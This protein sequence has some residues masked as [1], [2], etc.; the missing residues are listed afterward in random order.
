MT[1]KFLYGIILKGD[2]MIANVL[3]EIRKLDKTFSYSIP[4]DLNVVVGSRVLVPFGN[5]VLEGFV[6]E[7][8][9]EVDF[10]VKDIIKLIDEEPIL[11]EELLKLGN[12]MKKTLFCNLITCYQAMLPPALKANKNNKTTRKTLTYV[13]KGSMYDSYIPSNQKEKLILEMVTKEIPKL[14]LNEI[15]SYMVD[16]LIKKEVLVQYSKEVYRLT[17]ED[18]IE[19]INFDLTKQQEDVINQIKFNYQPYLLH[20]VTGSGKTE[21]Y[22]R[23]IEEVLKE[24]KKAIILLPEISLTPQFLNRFQKRFGSKIAVLHSKLSSGEKYDEWRKINKGEADIVIGAR[25]AV[26]APFKNIGII[27]LDEEHSTTYKQENNPNYNA[28]DIALTR[29]KYH[30]CPVV[31]GSAT[32]SV[33]SY[34]RAKMGIYKL[35]EM[36]D[37]VNNMLPL[38]KCIDM[39]EEFKNKN[40]IFSKLLTEKINFALAKQEQIIVLL[41]R[42]G[43]TT[44]VN[45]PNCGFVHKCD[46]C[47]IPLTYHLKKNKMLCH[48]CNHEENK[49]YKCDVCGES[50]KDRGLGTEKLEEE[51]QKKFNTAKI[52]RMDYD[53]TK[54]KTAH[55]KIITDFEEGKYDIL[56][57]TGMIAKGLDFPNVTVVGVIN[58][59]S[60]LMLPDFRSAENTFQ[61]LYQVAGRAGRGDKLGEVIIQCFNKD[62]YSLVNIKN[63]DYISFYEEEMKIRK[64]L[65]YPPYYNLTVIK[66]QS[67]DDLKCETEGKKIVD[68]LKK[69]KNI[70]VLGPSVSIHAKIN[71]V[72]NYQIIIK[73]KNKKEIAEALKFISNMYVNNKFVKVSINFNY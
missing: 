19:R 23:L 34:T 37:R 10:K 18:D 16:K 49:K 6:M 26:F 30:D 57:G 66:L 24:N 48:Y 35:L 63:Y 40:F 32:P 44:I 43:Y 71:N 55:K 51:L 69:N 9:E 20:G 12:Y 46:S 53:T 70:I 64:I 1:N 4:V 22:I 52:I 56:V 7:L 47:D 50:L 39:K 67:I 59:D 29:A 15:S 21:V 61:L 45:C 28:V 72:Y 33:E 14:K 62:H 36:T 2:K 31:L 42:R 65:K 17:V 5:Q 73:Y 13:K 11:N 68:Y 38:I 8:I 60:T 3:V 41:N 27:I 58:G 54:S 25:S